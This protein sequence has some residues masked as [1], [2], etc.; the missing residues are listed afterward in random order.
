[1]PNYYLLYNYSNINNLDWLS[2]MPELI[3]CHFDNI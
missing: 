2:K 1:M 3:N